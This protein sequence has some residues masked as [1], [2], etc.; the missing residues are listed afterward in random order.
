MILKIL[1]LVFTYVAF[2]QQLDATTISDKMEFRLAKAELAT[3][4]GKYSK[5][6]K[7]LKLNLNKN[8]FHLPTYNFLAEI[9][10]KKGEFV[11]EL[12]VYYYIVK[13]LDSTN[14]IK[15]DHL[16]NLENILFPFKKPSNKALS[17]YY[18]IAHLYYELFSKKI[19]NRNYSQKILNMSKK[20]FLVCKY[21]SFSV[22]DSIYF[23]AHIE[24]NLKDL[25]R[26]VE[27]LIESKKQFLDE[28]QYVEANNVN[29]LLADTLLKLGKR[30]ASVL[31][32]KNIAYSHEDE[33]S[34]SLRNY[35]HLY[36]NAFNKKFMFLSLEKGLTSNTNV[37]G[38]KNTQLSDDK[39][40]IDYNQNLETTGIAS[41]SSANIFYGDSFFHNYS[42]TFYLKYFSNLYE[43]KVNNADYK[44]YSANLNFKFNDFKKS[45]LKLLYSYSQ[46]HQRKDTKLD[47]KFE[48]KLTT[49]KF[50]I[51]YSHSLHTGVITYNV[52]FTI[53]SDPYTQLYDSSRTTTIYNT[54]KHLLEL[55][56][57]ISYVPYTITKY[58]VP[59]YS[60]SYSNGQVASSVS[61]DSDG[62][63]YN[64][65]YQNSSRFS[66]SVSNH[67]KWNQN[68]NFYLSSSLSK[69]SYISSEYSYKM[70][71]VNIIHSYVFSFL[72]KFTLN[73]KL[74][75]SSRKYDNNDVSNKVKYSFNLSTTF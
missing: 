39:S 8:Y 26:A 35:A 70:F 62:N 24:R 16:D 64:K 40:I 58:F 17:Y 14:I 65:E 9:Y 3:I 6:L 45:I 18:K 11:K 10:S 50:T 72:R 44:H 20:Y 74:Y 55:G 49:N 38:L 36:L 69:Y 67:I 32:L 34:S 75:Y 5:A 71:S 37:Y 30:N 47:E 31:F 28:M 21:Y 63:L 4:D 15:I 73:S 13:K 54:N 27:L 57:S 51:Q 42:L 59:T 53:D 46:T 2:S 23:L 48:K 52:P 22:P 61:R 56:T 41:T 25:P 33:A 66:F 60:I 12:K 7:I 68:S 1:I 43:K 29:Y 19:Y